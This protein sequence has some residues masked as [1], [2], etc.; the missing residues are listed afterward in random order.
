VLLIQAF[1]SA[2]LSNVLRPFTKLHE[3]DALKAKFGFSGFPVTEDGKMGSKLLGMI[4][5]RDIDFRQDRDLSVSEV[6]STDL[7]MAKEPCTLAEANTIMRDSKKGKLPIVDDSGALKALTSRSDLKK[8]RDFPNASKDSNKQLLAGAAIGT[9]PAD[10]ERLAL[11]VA[12]GLDVVVLDSSQGNSVYQIEMVRWVKATFPNLDVIAGNVVTRQQG[13]SLIK[14]GAD[15]LRIGMGVGSICT[16]Q[17]VCAVGRAQGSAVYHVCKAARAHGVPCIA[18]GGI[19][20][21]GQIVKALSLGASTVMMGSMLAGTE[22]APG[23]Y[24]YQDGVRLKRYRGMG[25][26]EAMTKD[27]STSAK[28]YFAED[29]STIKVAQGVS[30]AVV[31]KGSIRRYVPYLQQGLRHGLQDLGV[32]SLPQL[33]EAREAGLVRFELRSAAAQKEGRVHDLY[34]YEKRVM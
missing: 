21:S 15:G 19:S 34:T 1:A 25:S 10:K 5:N 28:R 24:F 30:G 29:A 3:V 22:E 2:P 8:S 4:T 18:D 13:L 14:A 9:R 11:L 31:D 7:T 20:S 26:I 27:N 23:Q 6:M 12:E 17:E 32:L 33:N 16:T